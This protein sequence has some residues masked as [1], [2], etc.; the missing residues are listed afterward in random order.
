[1]IL[2]WA[3]IAGLYLYRLYL[4]MAAARNEVRFNLFHF[5]LYVAAFEVAPL[6]LIYRLLIFRF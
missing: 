6:L 2:S 4:G 1:L 3:G 5:L